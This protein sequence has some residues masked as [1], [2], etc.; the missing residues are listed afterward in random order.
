MKAGLYQIDIKTI[1]DIN[2]NL[3]KE[4]ILFEEVIICNEDALYADTYGHKYINQILDYYKD[5]IEASHVKTLDHS[6][7]K[8]S[9]FDI[10]EEVKYLI[11]EKRNIES[12]HHEFWKKMKNRDKYD[13]FDPNKEWDL[14]RWG[15]Y[16]SDIT[17]RLTSIY[18][19]SIYPE[20]EYIPIQKEYFPTLQEDKTPKD[21]VINLVL[22][23]FP[24]IDSDVPIEQVIEFKEER[25]LKLRYF[26]LRDFIT[27]L[28]RENLSHSEIKD[29]LEYLLHE[30]EEGLK[31]AKLKYTTSTLE[32]ICIAGAEFIENLAKLKFSSAVKNLFELNM[33][34]FE[35]LEAEKNLKGREV[36]FIYYSNQRFGDK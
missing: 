2:F 14:Y 7:F 24:I 11:N 17:N 3:K 12:E 26:E 6:V 4:L 15:V 27:N 30:Y 19:N 20:N 18:L 13:D 8:D 31:Q 25:E 23:E 35:L 10:S 32:T 21:Q 5:L 28:A 33:Q 29:K 22:K 34:N 36:S 9:D 16:G 1:M